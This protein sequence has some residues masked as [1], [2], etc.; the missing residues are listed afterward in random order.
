VPG[1]SLT[2]V[3]SRGQITLPQ[4]VRKEAGIAPG[5][6][7]AIEVTGPG[8]VEVRVL[9][10]LTLAETFE[11]YK[12]TEPVGDTWDAE[13]WHDDAAKDVLSRRG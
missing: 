5:D 2:R 9:P 4:E 13:V 3:Q 6:A 10:K 12:I 1:K 8:I 7:V 11:R